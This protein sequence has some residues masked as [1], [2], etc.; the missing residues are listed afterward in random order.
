MCSAATMQERGWLE[1]D[2]AALVEVTSEAEAYPVEGALLSD[3]R[4]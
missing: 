2:Q 4:G 3:G 1:L